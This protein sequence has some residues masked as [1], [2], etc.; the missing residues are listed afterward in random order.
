MV[1]LRRQTCFSNEPP[2]LNV[3]VCVERSF[4]CQRGRGVNSLRVCPTKS[5]EAVGAVH[6]RPVEQSR[7]DVLTPDPAFVLDFL[8]GR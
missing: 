3:G 1:S 2:R 8:R 5:C 7:P 6:D 4:R